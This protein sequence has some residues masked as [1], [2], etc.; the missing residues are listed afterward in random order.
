MRE[1][2]EQSETA[3]AVRLVRGGA[4]MGGA[5]I[6]A[7]VGLIGG[8]PG[9]FAGAAAGVAATKALRRVGAEVEQRWLAPQQHVRAGTALGVAAAEIRARLEAGESLRDDG[10]FEDSDSGQSAGEEVLE[11]MLLAAAS[12]F[13]TRKVPLLGALYASIAFDR[14]VTPATANLLTNLAQRLTFRQLTLMAMAWDGDFSEA[15]AR[16]GGHGVLIFGEELGL[17]VDELARL[18]LIGQGEPG[19]ASNSLAI[20]W[21]GGKV[22]DA[23]A[24][25]LT[26]NGR[27]LYELMRLRQ[28]ASASRRDVLEDLIS[29]NSTSSTSEVRP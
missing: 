9:A 29:V 7:A 1:A 17:E 4:D 11:G 8:P 21:G 16:S 13:E 15:Y 3:L 22:V 5:T 23:G 6:G 18:G 28:I 25:T 19:G 10:F 24:V 20:A 2:T 12:A 14:S 26:A 27:R